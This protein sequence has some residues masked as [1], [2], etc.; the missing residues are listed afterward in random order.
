[1]RNECLL[2]FGQER[3]LRKDFELWRS[4]VGLG[5]M[6]NVMMGSY[7][8][9]ISSECTKGDHKAMERYILHVFIYLANILVLS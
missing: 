1:M 4:R 7:N 9:I 3:V 2:E 5:R 8:I 6:L